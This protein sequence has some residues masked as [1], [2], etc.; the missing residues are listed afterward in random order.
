[1][2]GAAVREKSAEDCAIGHVYDASLS[3]KYLH[4]HI[5]IYVYAYVD[6]SICNISINM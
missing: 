3:P 6:L 4:T 1:M 2:A 5:Q